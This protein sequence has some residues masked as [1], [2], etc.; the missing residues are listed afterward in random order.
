MS[1]A[2]FREIM[3]G[4]Y[5]EGIGYSGWSK[6]FSKPHLSA[7]AKN[8]PK[9]DSPSL[10]RNNTSYDLTWNESKSLFKATFTLEEDAFGGPVYRGDELVFLSIQVSSKGPETKPKKATAKSKSKKGKE[11]LDKAEVSKPV[12]NWKAV[13][14]SSSFIGSHIVP[15]FYHI[16]LQSPPKG[17][18]FL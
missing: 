6:D 5:A 3:R 2:H 4:P 14:D 17:I 18:V 10:I 8:L 7:F 12:A 1:G 11:K 9:V 13:E 16:C 15:L